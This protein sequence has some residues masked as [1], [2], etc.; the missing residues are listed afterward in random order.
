M[1]MQMT[2]GLGVC[3]MHS[4]PPIIPIVKGAHLE[5]REGLRRRGQQATLHVK[6]CTC[7]TV[8]ETMYK[9]Y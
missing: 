8:H 2:G 6:H 1:Y 9:Q 4:V 5:L 7:N 3:N